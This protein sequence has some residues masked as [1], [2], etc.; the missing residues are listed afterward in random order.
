M[1]GV[2]KDFLSIAI[3]M[4]HPAKVN[5]KVRNLIL[6]YALGAAMIALLPIPKIGLLQAITLVVL[7]LFLVRDIARLW[8]FRKGGDLLAKV[9]ILFGIA[10]SILMGF[11]T[12]LCLFIV[13]LLVGEPRLMILAPGVVAFSCFWGIGQAVHHFY[14]SKV[15]MSSDNS[16][17]SWVQEDEI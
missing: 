9:G 3:A 10:G 14:L 12:W 1:R 8:H 13:A 15:P 7:N 5:F 16:H 4:D 2:Q 17:T 6:D 11:L